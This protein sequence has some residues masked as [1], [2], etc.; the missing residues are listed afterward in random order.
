MPR[1]SFIQMS[2]LPDLKGRISYIA[3]PDRQENLFAVY[4]TADTEFWT[5]LARESRQEFKRCGTEGKC[6]EAR[7]MIIAL[8]ENYTEYDPDE[9]L[10]EFTE[11][12]KGQYGVE[13]T[14]ALH[15]NKTKNNYH[16]HL[17]FSERRLLE[18]PDNKIAT[19]AVYFDETG[20]RVR[21]KK[22][23][24]REDGTICKCC[25]VIPK[26]EIYEQHMFTTKD[27][28]F[29]SKG[30]LAEVKEM[31][32]QQINLHVREKE[33]LA[34][35]D[36]SSVYLPTKKIGKNNPLAEEIQAD[37]EARQDW[38]RTADLAL[39]VGVP[40]EKVLEIKHVEI[41]NRS[42]YSISEHGWLPGLFRTIVQK[43]K[44]ILE[45]LIRQAKLPPKPQPGIDMAVFKEMKELLHRLRKC[46]AE[47]KQI[48]DTELTELRAQLAETT[49]IFKGKERKAIE[50]KIET[51]DHKVSDLKDR[52][53]RM[54]QEQGYPDGQSFMA[55]YNK[56][57]RIVKRYEWELA[58]WKRQVEGKP[59]E[60][61]KPPERESVL[62][63]LH[64]IR[65]EAQKPP[66]RSYRARDER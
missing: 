17:I 14:S 30:F 26:G 22:E 8:P 13:C 32:T 58:E 18:T 12:F 3:S 41:Q 34:V 47:I 29:K 36:Q 39:V 52:I 11:K 35:F 15:Y 28:F 1:H 49:G 33:K 21:T 65:D 19:R 10:K 6:I 50:V 51:A 46:A 5:C 64:R 31:L 66:K 25:T 63:K 56:A 37:N 20:K 2:K 43:A 27:T 55:A 54:V 16:I 57:E 61:K 62:E 38:N 9:V 44:S 24:T 53:S 7:E 45:A 40:E 59:A 23:I 48:Q 60:E 42:K 4:D